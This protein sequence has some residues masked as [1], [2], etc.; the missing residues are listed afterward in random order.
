MRMAQA[1]LSLCN[2]DLLHGVLLCRVKPCFV[3]YVLA[4]LLA[5]NFV[6]LSLIEFEKAFKISMLASTMPMSLS[7]GIVGCFAGGQNP[8][9][10]TLTSGE[11][12]MFLFESLTDLQDG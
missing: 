9:G 7:F 3:F 6:H 5:R 11:Q 1:L 10:I 2:A 12:I 4:M 8:E